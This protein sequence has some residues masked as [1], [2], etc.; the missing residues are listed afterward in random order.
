MLPHFIADHDQVMRAGNRSDALHLFAA[1]QP[2]SGIVRIVEQDRP[3]FVRDRRFERIS[4][5]PPFG[6][7][8]PY[9]ARHAACTALN[10]TG[11]LAC[12][13]TCLRARAGFLLCRFRFSV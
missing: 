6:R 11:S 10:I 7:L 3:R 8:E 4:V 13:A 12:L 9:L 2:S 5:D 1:E